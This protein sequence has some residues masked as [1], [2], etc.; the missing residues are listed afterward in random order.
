MSRRPTARASRADQW[1]LVICGGIVGIA[2]L[3]TLLAVDPA[4]GAGS[5]AVD[6][7]HRTLSDE[8]VRNPPAPVTWTEPT[9]RLTFSPRFTYEGRYG[10]SL[11]ALRARR[12]PAAQHQ[13]CPARDRARPAC[14]RSRPSRSRSSSSSTCSRWPSSSSVSPSPPP[15]GRRVIAVVVVLV[16]IVVWAICTRRASRARRVRCRSLPASSLRRRSS[17]RLSTVLG[18]LI[19]R[20]RPGSQLPAL[21]MSL[22]GGAIAVRAGAQR[23]PV[24]LAARCLRPLA[25]RSGSGSRGSR[26]R[27][28]AASSACRADDGTS[29]RRRRA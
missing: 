23:G 27:S 10:A 26:A 15:P 9:R 21:L 19:V 16:L 24:S 28:P 14:R 25:R 2:G 6:V 12:L 4:R 20:E 5:G 18:W 29:T 8:H 17:C 1:L 11:V 22:L 7:T 3:L 13:P